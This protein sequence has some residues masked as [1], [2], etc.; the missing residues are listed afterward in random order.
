MHND[1][2][3]RLLLAERERLTALLADLEDSVSDQQD[4]D[5]RMAEQA[6][7]IIDRE[8]DRSTYE[9]VHEQLAEVDAALQRVEDGT[10]G[11]SEVS[12]RP[13]PDERLRAVPYARRLAEEQELA[14]NQTRA[15]QASNPDLRQ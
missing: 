6:K 1:E 7:D 12:G 15:T 2:A 10:Y 9:R 5:P 8:I 3:R 14:D 11:I 13:I 4:V